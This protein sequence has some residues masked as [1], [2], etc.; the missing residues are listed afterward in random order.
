MKH[1][2]TAI[3]IFL[4]LISC[5]VTQTTTKPNKQTLE[6]VWEI[7]NVK[8]IGEGGM[9]KSDLF[10]LAETDCFKGSEWVLQPSNGGGKITILNSD[11]CHNSISKIY[12]SLHEPGDGSYQFQFKFVNNEASESSNNKGYQTKINQFTTNSLVMRASTK[13]MEKEILIELTFERISNQAG[14]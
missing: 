14:L 6:G 1:Y 8:Y 11:L 9:Y 2:Y 12:W 4:S 13:N 10:D 3:F 7:T 5:S